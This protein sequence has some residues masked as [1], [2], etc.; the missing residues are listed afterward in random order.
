MLGKL[1]LRGK[2][3]GLTLL[4]LLAI[5]FVASIS[6]WSISGMLSANHEFSYAAG[7][8]TFLTEKEV[9]HLN[10]VRK[11]ENLFAEN[12]ETLVV[13]MDPTKCGL[14]KFLYGEETR[15]LTQQRPELVQYVDAIK[16]PHKDLHESA[17]AIKEAWRQIHPGLSMIL[18][19]RLD[20]HRRWTLSVAESLL[21]EKDITVQMDS[22]KCAF[23]KWLAGD[24]S[25][26]LTGEWPEFGAIIAKT[27]GHH[28]KL[29]ESAAM[30][31]SSSSKE[32]K[33]EIYTAETMPQ[34]AVVGKLFRDL[35][36]LEAG[37]EAAQ[38][39]SRRIFDTKTLPAL[40]S[41]KDKMA[42]LMKQF[43]KMRKVAEQTM[44]SK[45]GT[46]KLTSTIVTGLAFLIGIL[47]S[48]FIIRSI[49]KPVSRIIE[50]LNEGADQVASASSQVSDSGQQL[51]EG[52]S[53]QAASIEETS[54]SLEEISSMTRQNADNAGQADNLMKEVNQVVDQAN[55]SMDELTASME[56]I[57]KASEETS[58]I[59]KTI[60]EI[61]FQTNLLALNAAVEAAR[62]GE[63][64]AGFA[65]VADEV[66]SLAM[67][68]AA[69]AGNTADLIEGTV[70]KVNSGSEL[71]TKTNDAFD[72]VT[73]SARKVGE[74]VGEIAASSNEQSDGIEQVNKAVTEMDTVVQQ[75]AASAEESAS[76]SEEM[77][78]QA[79]QMKA[80]VLDLVALVGKS[81][82][83][84]GCPKG[85]AEEFF[86]NNIHPSLTR[87]VTDKNYEA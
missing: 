66:R 19:A 87:S 74:L 61:A 82:N 13:T 77:N 59:I 86:Y 22:A 47:M 54:S 21:E 65:V 60:D 42:G 62:A 63:A 69:A 11:V 52:A 8:D 35:Q 44:I 72:K 32:A 28:Q 58:K 38:S 37:L 51:A 7:L 24:E 40:Q 56:E 36:D 2:L 57:T 68:A 15:M 4:L 34:L 64:G 84:K 3:W 26:K 12:L 75:N 18:A 29:H 71:V 39:V 10:W 50:V 17:S 48:F 45:G 25:R 1:K 78:A 23:G 49:T 14:G 81:K 70:R 16:E 41:T 30:I 53:E 27:S 5:L 20:D 76:A 55:S 9:D 79:E 43:E 83:G 67:R 73:E 85:E 46:A 6:L 33:K 80:S 31:K